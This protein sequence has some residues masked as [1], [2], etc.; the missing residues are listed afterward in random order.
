MPLLQ[1]IQH[2]F[3]VVTLCNHIQQVQLGQP[4]KVGGGLLFDLFFLQT[5]RAQQK[6]QAQGKRSQLLNFELIHVHQAAEHKDLAQILL[7]VAHQLSID[8]A[9]RTH[10]PAWLKIV[11]QPL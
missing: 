4:E 9:E 6:L 3:R 5:N 2:L 11:H 7:V 1:K 8:N 10:V